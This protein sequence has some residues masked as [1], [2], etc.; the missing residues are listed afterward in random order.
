MLLESLILDSCKVSDEG[1]A[2]L[3]GLSLA[4]ALALALL[5][6]YSLILFLLSTIGVLECSP[7]V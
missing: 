2:D 5:C 1:M 3:K 6:F 4:L 7:Q